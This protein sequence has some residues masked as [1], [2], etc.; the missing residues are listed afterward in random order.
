MFFENISGSFDI[1]VSNPPYF[2]KTIRTKLGSMSWLRAKMALF[3]D[4]EGLAIYRQIIEE[5]DKYLTP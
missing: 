2:L 5:A 3:A 1:I 4:E